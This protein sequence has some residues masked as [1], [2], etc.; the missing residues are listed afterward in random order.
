MNNEYYRIGFADVFENMIILHIYNLRLKGAP[1]LFT[2]N[3]SLSRPTAI[4]LLFL[5]KVN[6]FRR[7]NQMQLLFAD[8]QLPMLADKRLI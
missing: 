4:I 8:K 1:Q 3:Y 5:I 6:T 7:Q 2:I